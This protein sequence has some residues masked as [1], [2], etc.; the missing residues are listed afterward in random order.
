MVDLMVAPLLKTRCRIMFH[1]IEDKQN[2]ITS[3]IQHPALGDKET[4]QDHGETRE[5]LECH[6]HRMEKP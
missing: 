5:K 4:N 6:I 1:V 3:V 2:Q